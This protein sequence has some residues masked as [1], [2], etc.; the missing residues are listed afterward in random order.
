MKDKEW[1]LSF[2]CP[3]RF[4]WSHSALKEGWDNTNVFQI[5]TLIEQKS[6][7]TCRQKVGR[8]LRLCVNQDGER[9]E[10]KDIN[11]LPV[12]ANESFAEFADTLQREIEQ[13]TG[14]KFGV[15]QIS[16]FSGM[17]YH[18]TKIVEKKVTEEQAEKVIEVL[19]TSGVIENDGK[20]ENAEVIDTVELPKELE[21]IKEA[22]KKIVENKDN[23]NAEV[24][25]GSSYQEKITEEK[26]ITYD[27]AAEIINHF[28]KKD[29][30]TKTGRI[31][32]TMKNAMLN[33]TLDVPKRFEAAKERLESIIIKADNKLP[34]HDGS[35]EVTV[36]L[37]KQ[38]ILSPEFQELWNKIK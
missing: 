7:L 3:L 11:V 9:I 1:L 14:I 16:L 2:E 27:D 18:E 28:E 24:L 38:I 26:T 13:E 6:T 12:V 19:K 25:K 22:V 4:I 30:I 31:K 17:I 29:Y 34:I 10:D 23:V 33:G 37:K 20:V 36:K 21:P 5:C 32:D 8:G 35:K 15:L